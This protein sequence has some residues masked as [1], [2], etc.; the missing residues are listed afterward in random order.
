MLSTEI[1][2]VVMGA[3]SFLGIAGLIA[4]LYFTLQIRKAEFSVRGLL[5]GES[6]FNA[7]QVLKVLAQFQDDSSRLVALKALTD[8]DTTKAVSILQ[9]CGAIL[10]WSN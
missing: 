4:Y 5:D 1:L 10:M 7:A 9:K 3:S 6:L 2:N 8:Y